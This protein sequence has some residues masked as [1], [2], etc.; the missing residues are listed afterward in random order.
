MTHR[1]PGQLRHYPLSRYR[2]IRRRPRGHCS[3]RV[4]REVLRW[5]ARVLSAALVGVEAALVRVEVDV[6]PGLPH[7]TTV[8]LPDSTVR[9]SRE[10]VRTAIRNAGYAFPL[11]RITV[12]LT[13]PTSGRKARR[14]ICPSPSGSWPPRDA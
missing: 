13:R 12:N 9:E 3:H 5:L 7:F 6:S 11:D 1:A 8:G 14:P 4:R 2:V 10:R